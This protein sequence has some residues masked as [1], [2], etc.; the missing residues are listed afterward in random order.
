[1]RLIMAP[2]KINQVNKMPPSN[3]GLN[4]ACFIAEKCVPN[5]KPAIAIARNKASILTAARTTLLGTIACELSPAT[6]TKITA[7][8]GIVIAAL[9]MLSDTWFWDNLARAT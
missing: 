8:H 3:I 1:M 4:P 5:P 6:A 7:N 9:S 2:P